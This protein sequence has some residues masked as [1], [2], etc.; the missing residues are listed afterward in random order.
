MGA[1]SQ[2]DGASMM[3]DGSARSHLNDG[4][5]GVGVNGATKIPVAITWRHRKSTEHMTTA[6]HSVVVQQNDTIKA[7][8]IKHSC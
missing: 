5:T 7:P 6:W 3:D 8:C 4:R 1:V 2:S